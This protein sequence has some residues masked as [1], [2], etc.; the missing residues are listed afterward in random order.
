M[1]ATKSNIKTKR[2]GVGQRDFVEDPFEPNEKKKILGLAF[3]TQPDS[4]RKK[5]KWIIR[6]K[7]IPKFLKRE[8]ESLDYSSTKIKTIIGAQLPQTDQNLFP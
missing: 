5:L 1:T 7:R 3:P 8:A 4:I 2:K 6:M